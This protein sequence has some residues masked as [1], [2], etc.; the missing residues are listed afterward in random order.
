M[1]YLAQLEQQGLDLLEQSIRDHQPEQVW[2]LFS[3]GHDSVV[4]THLAAQHPRFSGVVHIDTGTGIGEAEEY[5]RELCDRFG[6][7][8]RIYRARENVRGDGTPDPMN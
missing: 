7:P 2:A 4:S 5:V 1:S 6:W 8:L 3:G